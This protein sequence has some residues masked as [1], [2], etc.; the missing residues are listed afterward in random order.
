[1]TIFEL[2]EFCSKEEDK[3]NKLFYDSDYVYAT[4]N[5]IVIKLP[6]KSS[7]PHEFQILLNG[8]GQYKYFSQAT[9][10]KII[11][12]TI[13]FLSKELLALEKQFKEL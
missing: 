8:S 10:N 4:D 12:Q 2:E 5:C 13:A 3:N 1:M 11:E 9:Y 7:N 6:C